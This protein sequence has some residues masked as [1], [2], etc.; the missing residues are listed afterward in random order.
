MAED[1]HNYLAEVG[2]WVGAFV[3]TDPA[4]LEIAYKTRPLTDTLFDSADFPFSSLKT[5]LRVTEKRIAQ[6]IAKRKDHI[7]RAWL[8]GA[9][10]SLA[11]KA[12]IPTVDSSSRPII[13]VWSGVYDASDGT[14]LKYE[15]E[16]YVTRVV[17]LAGIRKVSDYHFN[18][19]GDRILHTRTNVIVKCCVYD[20][21]TQAAAI[22]NNSAVLLKGVPMELY[23]NGAVS[24]LQRDEVFTGQASVARGYFDQCIAEIER[25]SAEMPM[26]A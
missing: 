24:T 23:I 16:D 17:R 2:L 20:D 25:G 10:S 22:D 7:W 21:S 9:T 1:Y 11:H 4:A 15:S 12:N 14:E 6:A 5:S 3:A 19:D 13:G 18:A 8:L 26:A